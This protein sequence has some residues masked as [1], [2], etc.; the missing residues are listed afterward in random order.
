VNATVLVQNMRESLGNPRRRSSVVEQRFRK[1]PRSIPW[2]THKSLKIRAE[3]GRQA[4][5][6]SPR[7]PALV[8]GLLRSRS[9]SLSGPNVRTQRQGSP[10]LW[11]DET[12]MP[13]QNSGVTIRGSESA[14]RVSEGP[15]VARQ[16]VAPIKR[17]MS[18]GKPMVLLV[19]DEP[20]LSRKIAE[21]HHG[22]LLL[23]SSSRDGSVFVLDLP[24]Q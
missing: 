24:R 21:Q 22:R 23:E 10:N 9:A 8:H 1:L 13:D 7:T 14:G 19:E 20:T 11:D 6:P 17:D 3:H 15:S 16:D 12:V 5:N 18:S 2:R 4:P